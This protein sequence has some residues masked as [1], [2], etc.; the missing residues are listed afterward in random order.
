MKGS[1]NLM[2]PRLLLTGLS[3]CIL[4]CLR[5]WVRVCLREKERVQVV[6]SVFRSLSGIVCCSTG[7]TGH[8]E[9]LHLHSIRLSFPWHVFLFLY[10]ST[11][12]KMHYI[13][14]PVAWGESTVFPHTSDMHMI[15]TD[16]ASQSSDNPTVL[17]ATI[18]KIHI[19]DVLLK[20]YIHSSALKK[21]G[22]VQLSEPLPSHM[23]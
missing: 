13:R 5:L 3:K 22:G 19:F 17:F 4:Y 8:R 11:F 10:L 18:S 20:I 7:W 21:Q 23:I 6:V 15:G 1:T 2:R 9:F 12:E 16:K 14:C